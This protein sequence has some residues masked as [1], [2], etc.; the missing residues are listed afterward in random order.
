MDVTLTPRSGDKGRDIIAF[1]DDVGAIRILDQ[2][3]KY[4]QRHVVCAD[5]V[6]AMFGV[7]SLDQRAS[8]A[9]ITT[10][11]IFAPG[12]YKQFAPVMPPRLGTP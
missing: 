11:S 4:A 5:E 9:M 7:L 10:T 2:V 3:K 1:R 8:K 12:V 6:A